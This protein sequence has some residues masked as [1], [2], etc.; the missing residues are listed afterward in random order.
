M[1]GLGISRKMAI[2]FIL[3]Y[4]ICWSPYIL[5]YDLLLKNSLAQKFVIF[6]GFIPAVIALVLAI[7]DKPW[8]ATIIANFSAVVTLTLITSVTGNAYSSAAMY[9]MIAIQS[10]FLLNGIRVGIIAV[11]FSIISY[12]SCTLL[13][14]SYAFEFPM[15]SP[16]FRYY[17]YMNHFFSYLLCG[18]CAGIFS[19]TTYR[20]LNESKRQKNN[21]EFEAR[22]TRA[23]LD[24]IHQAIF[25]IA[26]GKHGYAIGDDFSK[27][28]VHFIGND[29]VAHTNPFERVFSKMNLGSED[30]SHI[31]SLLEASM[32]EEPICFEANAHIAPREVHIGEKIVKI[33]WS[34][35]EN[36]KGVIAKILVVLTDITKERAL[37]QT[38][39][40]N[41]LD[42]ERLSAIANIS[43]GQLVRFFLSAQKLLSEARDLLSKGNSL[44]VFNEV[45]RDLHTLK[46]MARTFNFKE[47]SSEVHE[48]EDVFMSTK[49]PV[50]D[51][52]HLFQQLDSLISLNNEYRRVAEE[53]LGIKL[54]S[55][56]VTVPTTLL[57]DIYREFLEVAVAMPN[58]LESSHFKG[59][60]MRLK[61]I[62]S[63]T[64]ADVL[65]EQI[66]GAD[67]QCR[68]MNQ[69]SLEVSFE[70]EIYFISRSHIETFENVFVH[71]FR[72]SVDHGF[73]NGGPCSVSIRSEIDEDHLHITYE[74][75]GQGISLQKL[76]EKA[77]Q[78][79][80]IEKDNQDQQT[81]LDA[82]FQP[83][84]S[85]ADTVTDIS[86]RGLGMDYVKSA[87]SDIGGSIQV[88][89]TQSL[90]DRIK[91]KFEMFFPKDVLDHPVE[92]KETPH[93]LG[94]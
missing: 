57:D 70:G 33:D 93:K 10:T 76:R 39:R 11:V 18:V 27:N 85:T 53:K 35:V 43:E 17:A 6:V 19:V 3:S 22:N 1:Q 7:R 49:P 69:Q 83:R 64:L 26:K 86:G 48:V 63:I 59:A 40:Q 67:K 87:L 51:K 52:T 14:N 47:I 60:L 77:T 37:E 15:E 32:D 71:L 74:D 21:A 41:K 25:S 54:E 42:I 2:G 13:I 9:V 16:L 66:R 36:R 38:H 80:F 30:L 82:I 73:I 56:R 91:I 79:G 65:Q 84:L 55:K 5:V 88:V 12:F 89:A 61:G 62:Y 75:S 8:I 23:I 78:A 94:A 72:N 68:D 50:E 44:S 28:L 4:C 34:F 46:G 45:T 58:E 92:H 29:S 90:N 81:L 24:S 31:K 20:Y